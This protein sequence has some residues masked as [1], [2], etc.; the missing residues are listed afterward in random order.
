MRT[1]RQALLHTKAEVSK[2][3]HATKKPARKMVNRLREILEL[4]TGQILEQVSDIFYVIEPGSWK[5]TYLSPAYST[6]TGFSRTVHGAVDNGFFNLVLPEDKHILMN[7]WENVAQNPKYDVQYRIRSADGSIL[8]M[9]DKGSAV[10]DTHGIVTRLVG[11]ARDQTSQKDL[12]EALNESETRLQQLADNMDEIFWIRSHQ[13]GRFV[14]ASPAFEKIWGVDWKK[15]PRLAAIL[16][17]IHPE[18]LPVVKTALQAQ[19]RSEKTSIEFRVIRSDGTYRWLWGRTFPIYSEEKTNGMAGKVIQTGGITTDVS[20]LKQAQVQLKQANLDLGEKVNQ[21][22][23]EIVDIYE[24]APIGYHAL[25]ENGLVIMINKT[26]LDWLGYSEAEVLG[27][28]PVIKLLTAESQLVFKSHFPEFKRTGYLRD[29]ELDFMRKDGTVL[30]LLI[31]ATAQYDADGKYHMSRSAVLDRSE[32]K[33]A[34]AALQ[35]QE[36]TYRA[37]FENSNDSIIL[38]S[39]QGYKLDANQHAL[40]LLG[41]SREEFINLPYDRLVPKEQQQEAA[42][43]YQQVTIGKKVPLIERTWIS[44]TGQLI[45][46]E[47]NLSP[48]FNE[49]GELIMVQNLARD[50]TERKRAQAQ[51]IAQRDFARQVMDVMGQGLL[52]SDADGRVEY[53]NQA[54]KLMLGMDPENGVNGEYERF[55]SREYQEG[56]VEHLLL[57]NQGTPLEFD[58]QMHTF[59]GDTRNMRITVTTR[60]IENDVVGT[61]AV[62]TDLSREKEVE[63]NL[64]ASREQLRQANLALE[65][66]A[67]MKDEFLSSMSH[68]LRTPLTGILGLSE[69]MRLGLYGE[70]SEKQLIAVANIEAS[71]K[72]LLE[73]VNDILDLTRIESGTM[74]LDPE[75][76]SVNDVCGASLKLISGL[77]HQ[78]NQV[79][80]YSGPGDS[81]LLMANSRRLKQI[82]VN[83]LRNAVKFTPDYGSLGLIVKTDTEKKEISLCVWDTGIGIK[84]DDM[85][86]LFMP[87][88]QLDGGLDRR[89]SGVGLGLSLVNKLVEL[90][91][92]RISVESEPG[93]G[94]RFTVILPMSEISEEQKRS[95][96]TVPFSEKKG[97]FWRQRVGDVL[98]ISGRLAGSE[99]LIHAL[100]NLGI[101]P[102]VCRLGEDVLGTAA[103]GKPSIILMEVESPCEPVFAVL[104]RLKSDVRTMSIPVL[105]I[106]PDGKAAD[107]DK[108]HL[109]SVCLQAI[110]LGAAGILV[111]PIS[112]I[113]LMKEL[114]NL[115]KKAIQ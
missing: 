87:F 107:D 72:I 76:C 50:V 64:L 33:K 18:D 105:M 46:M 112:L 9:R 11:T 74:N 26:E 13:T 27:V 38:V 97:V 84:D 37:M 81:L 93:L 100:S 75:L 61:I 57:G 53:L 21:Q 109:E 6:I 69:I 63:K 44:K 31:N 40:S 23:A 82:L 90:H 16:D 22:F 12:Q 49:D 17:K 73:L 111:E 19:E 30:P 83:L 5:C 77:V 113:L 39:P 34:Q 56:V 70:L 94:S 52:V 4:G 67:R 102:L 7:A 54:L 65:N 2:K 47:I 66:A 98:V 20:Q 24:H 99:K 29:L 28:M 62:F 89:Y 80:S 59:H 42:E 95:F 1:T 35:E 103:A 60:W 32:L 78:K 43:K 36:K 114:D 25:D 68:E 15:E 108:D 48:V 96:T 110:N 91:G 86:R 71:G 115:V 8:W 101:T 104:S 88:L 51:I 55:T 79:V 41:Y 92:G 106:R 10:Y 58:Y 3:Y 85:S 45:D 14:Y